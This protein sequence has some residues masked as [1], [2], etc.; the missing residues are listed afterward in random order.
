MSGGPPA[1]DK[2]QTMPLIRAWAVAVVC[3]GVVPATSRAQQPAVTA[4][5]QQAPVQAALDEARASEPQTIED[6]IRFCEVPAPPF[7]EAAR[8][9]VLRRE[10]TRLGLQNVRV[11]RVGNVLGDRLGAAARPRLVV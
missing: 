4:L 5:L 8:G 7:K 9:E 2:H 11:D 10:F 6:Q 3:A 1:R